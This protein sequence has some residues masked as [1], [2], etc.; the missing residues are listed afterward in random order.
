MSEKSLKSR[1][2]FDLFTENIRLKSLGANIRRTRRFILLFIFKIENRTR[3]LQYK[4]KRIT[5]RGESWESAVVFFQGCK[6]V[7]PLL[8]L[9]TRRTIKS[10]YTSSELAVTK[11]RRGN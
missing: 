10:H 9:L 11:S 8:N 7:F 5:A 3:A 4:L 1:S 2:I 6:G